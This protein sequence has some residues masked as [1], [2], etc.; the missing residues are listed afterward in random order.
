[1]DNMIERLVLKKLRLVCATILLFVSEL[2]EH[3]N[4]PT[5]PLFQAIQH[6]IL[7]ADHSDAVLKLSNGRQYSQFEISN[8]EW[9]QL[10]VMNQPCHDAQI[11]PSKASQ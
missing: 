1:M 4:Q 2:V 5:N 11:V 6:F 8:A 3:F 9:T 7:L 10:D